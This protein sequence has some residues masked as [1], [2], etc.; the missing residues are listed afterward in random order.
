M[1]VLMMEAETT[2]ETPITFYGTTGRN[3]QESC[4]RNT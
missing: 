3:N 1:F 4:H 2:P